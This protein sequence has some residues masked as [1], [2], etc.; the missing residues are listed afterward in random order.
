MER[1]GR[2]GRISGAANG[3]ARMKKYLVT[4]SQPD[5]SLPSFG[6]IEIVAENPQEAEEP[7][8]NYWDEGWDGEFIT[9]IE[10]KH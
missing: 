1:T 8:A 5:R 2:K 9:E 3:G 10:E 7:A 4:I 6:P